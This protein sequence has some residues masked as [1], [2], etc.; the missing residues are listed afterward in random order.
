MDVD[1]TAYATRLGLVAAIAVALAGCG[2]EDPTGSDE[3][4]PG[5]V[6]AL[7]GEGIAEESES[8]SL[9]QPVP[10]AEDVYIE[11]ITTGGGGCPSPGDVST[12]ISEDR[13][14]FLVIFDKMILEYPPGRRVQNLNCV[15]GVKLHVPQGFQV[16]LATVTTRGYA[17]LPSGGRARQTS[18]YFFAGDP[19]SLNPHSELKGP[20]DGL[21]EF[22]DKVPFSSLI[23]S[24][25]GD[26]AIFAV[27]T[28]INLNMNGAPSGTGY[29]NAET[30]DGKYKK[31][32]HVQWRA[33]N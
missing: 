7:D 12:T 13:K 4:D 9:A 1:I 17:Y 3:A 24:G 32:F 6:G 22:T 28:S 25:C 23:W 5:D 11:S 21:Y 10:S 33:C 27:N 26:S 2:A 18:S 19:L 16:S 15:A 29:F 31:L 14:S 20:H 30:V 8:L